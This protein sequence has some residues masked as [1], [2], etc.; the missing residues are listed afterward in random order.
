MTDV[1]LVHCKR[2]EARIPADK[3]L[4]NLSSVQNAT[5]CP[6]CGSTNNTYNKAWGKLLRAAQED[7]PRATHG[8]TL[9]AL[10]SA[11]GDRDRE[12]VRLR[13]AI[14]DHKVSVEYLKAG[15]DSLPMGLVEA[16]WALWRVLDWEEGA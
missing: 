13:A 3:L 7:G 2:C 16:N 15:M 9:K 6:L 4:P 11:R 14:R 8:A 5:R 12:L 10:R 1:V